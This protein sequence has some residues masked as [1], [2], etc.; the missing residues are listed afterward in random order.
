[1][2]MEKVVNLQFGSLPD[3]NLT[4]W[5]ESIPPNFYT[6]ALTPSVMVFG[7]GFLGR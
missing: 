6:E 7:S 2:T 3:I 4:V 1:M 5:T